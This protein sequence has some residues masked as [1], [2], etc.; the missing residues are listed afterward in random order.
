MT[1]DERDYA[2]ENYNRNYCDACDSSPCKSDDNHAAEFD[3]IPHPPT[4]PGYIDNRYYNTDY[5]GAFPNGEE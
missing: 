3:T 2:E 5:F 4:W 1:G